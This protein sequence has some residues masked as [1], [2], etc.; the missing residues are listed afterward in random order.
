MYPPDLTR[1][2]PYSPPYTR[3]QACASSGNLQSSMQ[4]RMPGQSGVEQ[5]AYNPYYGQ[6]KF[7]RKAQGLPM[8]SEGKDG[9][10]SKG[11]RDHR[12]R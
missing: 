4:P 6:V 7:E 12:R 9:R 8:Y 10:R 5:A 2:S 3:M 11:R 1:G